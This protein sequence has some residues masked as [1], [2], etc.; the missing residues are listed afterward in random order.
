VHGSSG[1]RTRDRL[2]AAGFRVLAVDVSE[3]EKA[4]G[5]VTCCSVIVDP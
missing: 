2:E 4:E 3:M 1:P 5:A